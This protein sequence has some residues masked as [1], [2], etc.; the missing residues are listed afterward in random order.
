VLAKVFRD[1]NIT[2]EDGVKRNPELQ[3]TYLQLQVAKQG[4]ERD[5][6]HPEDRV[7]FVERARYALADAIE[8]GEPLE[9]MRMRERSANQ[10][11]K[12]RMRA[13]DLAPAR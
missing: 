5:I 3:G 6:G 9:P 1:P 4:A 7:R 10:V 13:R 2:P 12:E 11:E 8:R